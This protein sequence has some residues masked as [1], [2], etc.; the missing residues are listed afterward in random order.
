MD[1][2]L[3]VE[4]YKLNIRAGGVIIHNNKVLAHRN[5]NKDHYCLP[6]GRVEIGE[7]SEET[8]KREIKEELGKDIQI[9]KYMATI[10]NFF[11]MEGKKYHEIYYIYNVEFEKEEDKKIEY[12]MNNLEGKNYL[13][14]QWI[15]LNDIEKYNILPACIKDILKAKQFPIHIISKE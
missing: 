1:L 7:T 3:D 14:Y 12:K 13:Q 4:D 15:D 2:T 11:K 8:I 6:G 10:E 5:I 9:I